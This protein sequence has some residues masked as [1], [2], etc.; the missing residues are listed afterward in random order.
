MGEYRSVEETIKKDNQRIFSLL[1]NYLNFSPDYVKKEEVEEIV[2]S[3]LSAEYAFAVILAAAFGMDIVE[4]AHDREFFNHYFPR[5]FHRLDVND[6][7]NNPYY[8]NIN[9]PTVKVGSS[10]LKKEKFLP[11]EGFVCDDVLTTKEGRQIPQIGFFEE[12]FSFPAILENGRVWMTITPNEIETMKEAV[13]KAF[14]DV[15]T[16]GLGLGYYAYMVS[17]KDNVD[18]VT[19]VEINPDIIDLFKTYIFPQFKNRAKIHIVQGDAFLFA[20]QRL[21]S[22]AY[23]FIFTDL[24]HDVSDGLPMYL[25]MK[26]YESLSPNATF[27]Y[28]I[29]KTLRCY[30]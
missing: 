3:G 21:E 18:S 27:M 4:N 14:G 19:I 7:S 28:W 1:S 5:M 2:K 25:R 29:E 13:E 11:Y 20:K 17:E 8:K 23:D 26:E 9:I 6:Y 12:E 15:L 16:F 30:L 10:E 24:W 22:G